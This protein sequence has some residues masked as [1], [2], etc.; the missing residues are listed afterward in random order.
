MIKM[1]R[2]NYIN[3]EVYLMKKAFASIL[4]IFTVIANTVIPCFAE[5]PP[6][7]EVHGEAGLLLDLKSGRVLY[8]KNPDKKLYPASTTKI[9]TAVIVLEEANLA[10]VVT[11]TTSAISPITLE[12]SSMGIL[13]GEQLTVEQLVNGMLVHSAN[14]A[15]NVLAVHLA[16]S[17]EA[18]AE[19][20]NQKAKSLGAVN[21]NFVNP[22]GF[23]DDNHY[24]TAN[25]L[26]AIARY[27]MTNEKISAKFR[28]IV[29]TN[30]YIIEPT[31][32]YTETRYL[33]TTN[34]LISKIRNLHHFYENAIGIK[35]GYTGQAG[36]CLVAAAKK[37]ETEFL[38]VVMKCQNE[39][40]KAG[41]YS[42]TDTRALF[43]YAFKN[44]SYQ[45]VA[46]TTDIVSDS[47]V[48][49]AK[50]A[51]RVALI[52][53]KK[54]SSLLPK[55]IDLEKDIEKKITTPDEEIKAPIAKGDVLGS[56][57]YL[58]NGEELGTT[59]LV[60]SNDVER[61]T[62]LFIIHG[63]VNVITSPFFY[64]PIIIL[65]GLIIYFKVNREKRRR[66]RRRNLSYPRNNRYR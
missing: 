45:T 11:A 9:L 58:Y 28:E 13:I 1:F 34:H 24:T 10:D 66:N 62:L 31:N 61:D 32:K 35:T 18:F 16:G 7:P 63:F 5:V 44:Y 54:V 33:S 2:Y 38:T 57:T 23:H 37:D 15:A 8:S 48:Y 51:V 43:D 17:I 50:D 60:A 22:H 14:D 64:V 25:D 29:A 41:A 19:K 55:N 3:P 39:G 47:K 36:H 26:A 4:I 42:F 56:V 12:D 46:D 49:E 59:N 53:E 52:P 40:S 20:M 21:S 6:A 30:R 27:A 65:A